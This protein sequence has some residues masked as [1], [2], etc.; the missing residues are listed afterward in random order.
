MIDNRLSSLCAEQDQRCRE[1]VDMPM[2]AKQSPLEVTFAWAMSGVLEEFGGG[3]IM[4]NDPTSI[5][6][7][8][9]EHGYGAGYCMASFHMYVW[10][11]VKIGKYTADFVIA[12]RPGRDRDIRYLV[13]ECDG[14]D[15]H[16]RTKQQAEHDRRRDREMQAGGITVLRVTGAEV[17]RSPVQAAFDVLTAAKKALEVHS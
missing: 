16:E 1:F 6:Q 2:N 5:K 17:W 7:V 9:V 14:H 11:Q 4:A 3:Q 12:Y 15:F 10:S 8:E 13:I